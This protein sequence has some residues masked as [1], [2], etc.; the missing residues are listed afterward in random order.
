MPSVWF[1][2]MFAIIDNVDI[3]QL[4]HY[5]HDILFAHAC[6]TF[7]NTV[8]IFDPWILSNLSRPSRFESLSSLY[9]QFAWITTKMMAH[10]G[11]S[12]WFP[13]HRINH[14][15]MGMTQAQFTFSPISNRC[16]RPGRAH[17]Y[18]YRLISMRYDCIWCGCTWQMGKCDRYIPV[19]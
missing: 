9:E 7:A 8:I 1:S 4:P 5:F 3:R 15:R 17:M 2:S 14:K 18:V 10:D 19:G 11:P 13:P 12:D 6:W 16:S